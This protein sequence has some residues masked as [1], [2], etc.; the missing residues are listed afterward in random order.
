M[1]IF[2]TADTHFG[3]RGIIEYCNRPFTSV[4]EMDEAIIKAWNSVVRLNDTVYHLGDFAWRFAWRFEAAEIA[5]SRLNGIKHLIV[6][7]HDHAEVRKLSWAS[8]AYA[9][10]IKIDHRSIFLCHY[11]ADGCRDTVM[12]HGHEHGKGPKRRRTLDI[13]VDAWRRWGFDVPLFAPIPWD[14]IRDW[15]D[16]EAA[17]G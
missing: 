8:V 12:L 14:V 17:N 5:F 15:S 7:N 3:H 10:R 11:A 4:E 6:G 2:F 16:R 13:G 1:T 9:D